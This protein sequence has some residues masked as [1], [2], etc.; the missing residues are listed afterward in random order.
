VLG[1]GIDLVD[2]GVHELKGV[3]GDWRLFAAAT[4]GGGTPI[5]TPQQATGITDRPNLTERAARRL[6][7][8]A[9]GLARATVRVLRHRS[10]A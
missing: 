4:D 7:R 5:A 6:A 2:R 3:P 9:P 1:S 8:S 10:T